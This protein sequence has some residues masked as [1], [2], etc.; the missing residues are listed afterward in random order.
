MKIESLHRKDLPYRP[1]S[2]HTGS[3]HMWSLHMWSL[4]RGSPTQ[5]LSTYRVLAQR[6]SHTGPMVQVYMTQEF[7]LKPF[8]FRDHMISNIYLIEAA[9]QPLSQE[10][11]SWNKRCPTKVHKGV[12]E[13]IQYF[14]SAPFS[15]KLRVFKK[16]RTERLTR[17]IESWDLKVVATI[18]EDLAGFIQLYQIEIQG[19]F[20][21]S[22]QIEGLFKPAVKFKDFSRLYEP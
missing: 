18:Y 8:V 5:G 2:F 22:S 15:P 3:L 11:K 17:S 19:V 20:K 21:T 12:L 4:H 1:G 14:E 13:E 9:A 6:T 7:K 10:F 16:R